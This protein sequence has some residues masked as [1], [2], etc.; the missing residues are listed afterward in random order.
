MVDQDRR[1]AD[2]SRP[3]VVA[4]EASAAIGRPPG[5][6]FATAA[7]TG[8]IALPARGEQGPPRAGSQVRVEAP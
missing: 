5:G 6:A 3:R 4:T 2:R 7:R 1:R 8:H